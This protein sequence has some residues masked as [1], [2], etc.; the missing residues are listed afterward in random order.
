MRDGAR[1]QMA[2][3]EN[4]GWIHEGKGPTRAKDDQGSGLDDELLPAVANTAPRSPHSAERYQPSTPPVSKPSLW[5][6]GI[7]TV[8]LVSQAKD[9]SVLRQATK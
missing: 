1:L 7:G 4:R 5:M 3:P 6:I 8:Q 2:D 9:P